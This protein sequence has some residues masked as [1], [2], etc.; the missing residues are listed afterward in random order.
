[1][2]KG[3]IE[4]E[5]VYIKE[6]KNTSTIQKSKDSNGR[7]MKFLKSGILYID[8]VASR[9]ISLRDSPNGVVTSLTY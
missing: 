5:M 2:G 1:M 4:W 7:N 9:S 8:Q 6:E 3:E